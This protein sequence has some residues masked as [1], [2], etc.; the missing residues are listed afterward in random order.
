LLDESI[1]NVAACGFAGMNTTDHYYYVG[2]VGVLAIW[3]GDSEKWDLYSTE[4][5]AE[6]ANMHARLFF[7]TD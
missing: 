1:E 7:F 5:V 4:G 6:F 2:L 3:G